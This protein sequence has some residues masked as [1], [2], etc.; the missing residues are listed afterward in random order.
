M[1]ELQFR[2]AMSFSQGDWTIFATRPVSATILAL[3]VL[4]L[5]LPTI[6]KKRKV[7]SPLR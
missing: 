1:L 4:A 2:R 3:A 7:L 6:L 5:V